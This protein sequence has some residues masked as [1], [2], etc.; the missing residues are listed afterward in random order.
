MPTDKV[1]TLV[2][3]CNMDDEIETFV[4]A[5]R[6]MAT[7]ELRSMLENEFDVG[8]IKDKAEVLDG[9]LP[10]CIKG[11]THTFYLEVNKIL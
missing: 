7:R 3:H 2:S 10:I 6:D 11:Y 9:P 4:F 1:Y 5:R 8:E